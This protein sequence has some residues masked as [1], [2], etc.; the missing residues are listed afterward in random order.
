M[1]L[2]VFPS[3]DSEKGMYILS[4]RSY[5]HTLQNT[6]FILHKVVVCVIFNRIE[7]D[8]LEFWRV[9]TELE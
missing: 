7:H 6:Y 1:L 9:I 2:V 4:S 3:M 8:F 5:S